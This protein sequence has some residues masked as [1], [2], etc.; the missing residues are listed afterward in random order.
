MLEHANL[1]PK[2]ESN[3]SNKTPAADSWSVVHLFMD[4]RSPIH[5]LLGSNLF[6]T[7]V[8]PLVM[9][10]HCGIVKINSGGW[11]SSGDQGLPL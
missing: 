8:I 6:S 7:L 4:S 11:R 10:E 9:P 2:Y 5:V 3:G 1:C